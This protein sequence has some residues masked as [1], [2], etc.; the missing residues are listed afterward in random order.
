MHTFLKL[1]IA[2]FILVISASGCFLKEAA[3]IPYGT[4]ELSVVDFTEYQY[5]RSENYTGDG[6]LT[7]GECETYTNLQF[8]PD[9]SVE[10]CF[11]EGS[12]LTL[13][14]GLTFEL[15]YVVHQRDGFIPIMTSGE[16]FYGDGYILLQPPG[17]SDR[18]RVD[19][20]D[21]EVRIAGF[22]REAQLIF[23]R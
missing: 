22:R 3:A 13:N 5:F 14:R 12:Y 8:E 10:F 15:S 16:F 1:P 19:Y 21:D 11:P 23:G 20:T 17:N 18:I 9:T 7:P 6:K 4:H 2:A